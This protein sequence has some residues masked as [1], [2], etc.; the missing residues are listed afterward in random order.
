[1]LKKLL[2]LKKHVDVVKVTEQQPESCLHSS[3]SGSVKQSKE[4]S[5]TLQF[6]S[7]FSDSVGHCVP[8]CFPCMQVLVRSLIP[9]PHSAEHSLNSLHSEKLWSTGQLIRMPSFTGQ[10]AL[11]SSW[12]SQGSPSFFGGIHSRFLFLRPGCVPSG[13]QDLEHVDPGVNKKPL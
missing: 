8:P 7:C 10:V 12:P 11:S 5:L 9:S 13:I 4:Q 2:G 6:S 1:M 3:D